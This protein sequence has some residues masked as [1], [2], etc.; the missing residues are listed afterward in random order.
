MRQILSLQEKCDPAPHLVDLQ[1]VVVLS[2]VRRVV[3]HIV[4]QY[5]NRHIDL[6]DNRNTDVNT[7]AFRLCANYSEQ[8]Q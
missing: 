6:E 8:Q 2:K 4:D 3:V 5:L 1:H 7:D